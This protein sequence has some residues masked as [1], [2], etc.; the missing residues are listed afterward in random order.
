M[1][2]NELGHGGS[3]STAPAIA[4]QRA[5]SSQAGEPHPATHRHT[6]ASQ[7]PWPLH[8]AHLEPSAVHVR[9]GHVSHSQCVPRQPRAQAQP[10]SVHVPWA[11]QPPHK[12]TSH[13]SPA[14]PPL[15]THA[16]RSHRPWSRQRAWGHPRA[17]SRRQGEPPP[18]TH[19]VAAHDAQGCSE[20]AAH[21]AS[22][23]RA[24]GALPARQARAQ[25]ADAAVGGRG[26]AG[27]VVGARQARRVA[28]GAAPS[29]A[30]SEQVS[31]WASE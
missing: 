26:V 8:E 10:R 9:P 28:A 21:H 14:Q 15:H 2:C 19:R 24:V 7:P 23:L 30:A 27:A 5:F 18:R 3:N 17:E 29:W 6:P 20:A 1:L 4:C 22:R 16:P 11:E 12:S 25:P 31:K 13:S